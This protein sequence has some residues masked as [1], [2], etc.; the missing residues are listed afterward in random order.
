MSQE[1]SHFEKFFNLTEFSLSKNCSFF[2]LPISRNKKLS[3]RKLT[4]I[5]SVS[6][7]SLFRR[8]SGSSN[9]QSWTSCY[10]ALIPY[11]DPQ[12]I[13]CSIFSTFVLS[14]CKM[15]KILLDSIRFEFHFWRGDIVYKVKIQLSCWVS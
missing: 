9:F 6:L 11:L 13:T 12:S 4:M 3:Y 7:N 5:S 15:H 14:F 1:I 10:A 8:K 2:N